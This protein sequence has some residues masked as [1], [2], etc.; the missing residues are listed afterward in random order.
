MLCAC[1]STCE[2]PCGALCCADGAVCSVHACRQHWV[3]GACMQTVLCVHSGLCKQ[4]GLCVFFVCVCRFG[5][6]NTCRNSRHM[7]TRPVHVCRRHCVHICACWGA[8]MCTGSTW[9]MLSRCELVCAPVCWRLLRCW[10]CPELCAWEAR[11]S[12]GGV[13]APTPPLSF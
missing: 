10:V 6:M 2:S 11:G 13:P 12:G 5:Y 8:C 4:T 3:F 1:V 9:C 7:Q